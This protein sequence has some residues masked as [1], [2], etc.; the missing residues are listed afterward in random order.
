M[1]TANIIIFPQKNNGIDT[2]EDDGNNVNCILNCLCGS[3]LLS[4]AELD[5]QGTGGTKL[6]TDESQALTSSQ[7]R[8]CIF[9]CFYNT[10][11]PTDNFQLKN[12]SLSE[13]YGGPPATKK[14]AYIHISTINCWQ[15]GRV[16]K[17][18]D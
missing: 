6:I 14:V 11:L 1:S 8:F 12:F 17:A 7:V 9:S 15:R 2:D 5:L 16:V 10:R 13:Q 18:P 4:D 3:Q